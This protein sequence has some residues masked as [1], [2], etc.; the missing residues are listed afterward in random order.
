MC[1]THYAH[2]AS[3]SQAVTTS[4]TSHVMRHDHEIFETQVFASR[5]LLLAQRDRV[6]RCTLGTALVSG[7][8][9]RVSEWGRE[10]TG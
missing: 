4:T 5:V 3:H 8:E 9:R 7:G 1:D 2:E 6:N 10:E